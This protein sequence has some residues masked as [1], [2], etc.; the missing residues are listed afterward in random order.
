M[1]TGFL[2]K[3]ITQI[4]GDVSEE[5]GVIDSLGDVVACTASEQIGRSYAEIINMI[6][7]NKNKPIIDEDK[8]F[9]PISD[10]DETV[11]YA[12]FVTGTNEAAKFVCR[13]TAAAIGSVK[14]QYDEKYD[15]NF[16]IK[17]IITDNV[18]AGDIYMKA[19][20]LE[21]SNDVPRVVFIIRQRERNSKNIID[22]LERLFPNKR[23]DFIIGVDK[24]D[25]AVI[26]EIHQDT[27]VTQL[28]LLAKTIETTIVEEFMVQPVIGIGTASMTLKEL[29]NSYR[30]AASA[31]DVGTI[32]DP[33][34][35][36]V[37]Y[38]NLGVGRLIYQL[39][40][41]LCELFMSEIF[42]NSSFEM[43]DRETLFSVDKFFENNLNVS[44]TARTLFV[45]RNTLVYRLDKV[46]K[47]T[48]LDLKDFDQAVIFKI[49]L[50]VKKYL[51]SCER[52]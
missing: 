37:S 52:R 33:E 5:I 45:H 50:M 30:E 21:I 1:T 51:N 15:K 17:N 18:L 4:K 19:K 26:K 25:V 11:E 22:A 43:L 29:A 20:E 46:K 32:F 48:G 49:A 39:P 6:V 31:I 7:R 2:Q 28:L 13:A 3:I 8:V 12:V 38:E 35:S 16:F 42:K 44:E 36:V 40:A 47:L 27:D 14:D 34:N 23:N 10:D 41:T 24:T 9:V